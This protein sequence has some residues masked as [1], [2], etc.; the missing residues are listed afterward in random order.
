MKIRKAVILAAGLG[1]RFFPI[2]KSVDKE[3][4]P[5][6]DKPCIQY[7]VEEAVAS[8]IKEI[9][10]VIGPNQSLVKKYFSSSTPYLKRL[11]K[12]R[13]K[14][15]ALEEIKKLEHLARFIFVKQ[16]K[17]L[18]DGHAILCA[19]KYLKDEAFAVLFGDDIYDANPPALKQLIS[20]YGKFQ[21]PIVG[22]QKIDIRD[23]HK[24]GMAKLGRN[25]KVMELVEKPSP[26]KAPS[27]LAVVGKYIITPELLKTLGNSRPQHDSELRLIDGMRTFIKN[28]GIHGM[29]IKGRRFDTG[30]KLGYLKAVLAYSLK[31]PS[32]GNEIKKYIK[33]LDF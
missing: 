5:I 20:A 23:S 19:K 6:I 24:Y 33:T 8:G 29:E 4:L 28:S 10:F 18:G 16:N 17:P 11:L 25:N 1:T 12:T 3:M 7:L 31:S 14:T 2:T 15:T 27:N 21:T 26:Q 32:Y 30:D 13:K 9:I 22:L